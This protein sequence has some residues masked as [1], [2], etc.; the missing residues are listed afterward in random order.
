[1]S[2]S[3]S[4]VHGP[5]R[6]SVVVPVKPPARGKS[7][8]I[9][10]TDEAR[11][12]LAEAFALDTLAAARRAVR[13]GGVL[14]V[15]DDHV[16]A[17]KVARL[18]YAVIP[19]GVG[20]DLNACLVQAVAE[21]GRRWPGT[22]PAALLAD[23][24]AL[25]PEELDAALAAAEGHGPAFVPDALGTGTCLYTALPEE[26]DPRFGHNSRALHVAA[27]VEEL[28]G[29]WPH[30]RQDVDDMADLG[31]VMALGVGPATT[32]AVTGG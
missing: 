2:A 14:V 5:G 19:D 7:R 25:T 13:V 1:M 26:F 8:I 24:P 21:A 11:R 20:D 16:F 22:R 15:T 23:L 30:L 31:R 27:G 12:E 29:D 32:A 10:L 9:G 4:P 6:F 28:A 17:A 3:P 18:G